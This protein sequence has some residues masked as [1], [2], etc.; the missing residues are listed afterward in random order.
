[1]AEELVPQPPKKARAPRRRRASVSNEALAINEAVKKAKAMPKKKVVRK[2]KKV[3][4][5]KAIRRGLKR[6]SEVLNGPSKVL[7][8]ALVA[9]ATIE[10]VIFVLVG[11]V[12]GFQTVQSAGIDLTFALMG[13]MSTFI[14]TAAVNRNNRELLMLY[15]VLLAWSIARMTAGITRN[16]VERVR[17]SALCTSQEALDQLEDLGAC[18]AQR[19]LLTANIVLS[20]FTLLLVVVSSWLAMRMSEKIQE[21]AE[22][23]AEA[24]RERVKNVM[25]VMQSRSRSMARRNSKFAPLGGSPRR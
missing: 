12:S 18:R 5:K 20:I 25:A 13:F 7:G 1:M 6:I 21:E 14:G 15:F 2:S 24:E 16:M 11:L 17:L 9:L 3:I 19:M 8:K 22:E 4:V 10:A 23:A